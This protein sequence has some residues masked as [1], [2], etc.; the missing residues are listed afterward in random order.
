L[1]K[2]SFEIFVICFF[3]DGAWGILFLLFCGIGLAFVEGNYNGRVLMTLVRIALSVAAL[4]FMFSTSAFADENVQGTEQCRVVD[5]SGSIE[6]YACRNSTLGSVRCYADIE[7]EGGAKTRLWGGC[8]S[9][10]SD[11][12]WNGSGRVDAC[13]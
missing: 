1:L 5:Q 13:E 7:L 2:N 10:F 8:V 9:T 11:C 12:W 6:P 3:C 4:F